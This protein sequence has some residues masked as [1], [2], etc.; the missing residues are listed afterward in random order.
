LG[1]VALSVNAMLNQQAKVTNTQMQL[2]T[3]LKNLTPAD[4]PIAAKKVLDIQERLDIT[5][6]F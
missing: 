5:A 1:T 2:S 4:D 6:Q 3:E